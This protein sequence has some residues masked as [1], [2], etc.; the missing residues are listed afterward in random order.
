MK[1]FN[2]SIYIRDA[3][4]EKKQKLLMNGLRISSNILLLVCVQILA[5]Q[6]AIYL[7]VDKYEIDEE[8]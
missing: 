5:I 6:I 7:L 8:R 1:L 2:K 4:R 3:K